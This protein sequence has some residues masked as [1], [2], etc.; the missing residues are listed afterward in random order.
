MKTRRRGRHHHI[1]LALSALSLLFMS[2]MIFAQ[3]L[4]PRAY[5]I[6]PYHANAVTL[7]WAYY[8]GNLDFNGALP[9]DDAT[10][11]YNV[12]IASYYHSFGVFGRSANLAASL[13]YGGKLSGARVRRRTARLPFRACGFGL[14]SIDQP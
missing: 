6:T 13:P 5:L 11:K 10:G 4:A 14:S 2:R 3:D 12:S 9:T 8:D 7:T 1:L